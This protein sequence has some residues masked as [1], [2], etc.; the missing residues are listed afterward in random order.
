MIGGGSAARDAGIAEALLQARIAERKA[1]QPDMSCRGRA[2]PRFDDDPET[3][4]DMSR[5]SGR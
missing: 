5:A 2:G 4:G 3:P 1:S